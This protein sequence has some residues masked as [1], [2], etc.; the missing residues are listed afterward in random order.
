M[1]KVVLLGDSIRLM[2]YGSLVPGLLGEEFE[3]WQPEQNGMYAENVLRQLFDH[4]ARIR[5]ADVVHFNAGL[6]DVCDLFGDGPF[7]PK[8]VYASQIFRIADLLRKRGKTVVFASTT[9]VRPENP[10]NRNELIAAYNEAV[11]PALAEKGVWINDLY[12]LL[13]G[14]LYG[15]VS[16]DLIHLTEK[17]AKAAAESTAESVRKA[18]AG[19]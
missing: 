13:A 18:A 19:V 3:V 15:N 1:K 10:H 5:E 4:D 9:P 2:G 7:T 16:D 14:D 6:W 11:L 17:G 8:E 12:S